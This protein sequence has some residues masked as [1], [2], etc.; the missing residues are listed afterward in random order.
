V[1]RILA[2]FLT[3][4][5]IGL[6]IFLIYSYYQQKQEDTERYT[7]AV[8]SFY[9][10]LHYANKYTEEALNSK[11]DKES[12]L[13]SVRYSAMWLKGT[14]EAFNC[15]S[16]S[17][18]IKGIHFDKNPNFRSLFFLYNLDNLIQMDTNESSN[19][20]EITSLHQSLNTLYTNLTDQVLMYKSTSHIQGIIDEF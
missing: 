2:I 17:A 10:N 18:E 3:I 11:N 12:F 7:D 6:S 4:V 14:R 16:E 9:W 19:I 13:E 20:D 8:R 15:L 5:I 1:N